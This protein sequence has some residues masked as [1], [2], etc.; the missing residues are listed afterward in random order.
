MGWVVDIRSVTVTF[1]VRARAVRVD[2]VGSVAP[3][4]ALPCAEFAG[5]CAQ[6]VPEWLW[7][8]GCFVRFGGFFWRY[9]S[10]SDRARGLIHRGDR[11]GER[12]GD[13]TL[14]Q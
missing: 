13:R 7:N 1:S 14:G 12:G 9:K 2:S 4:Q 6:F 5:K 10:A 3:E 11:D 8:C